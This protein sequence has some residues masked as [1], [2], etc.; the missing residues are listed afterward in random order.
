LSGCA[1][2]LARYGYGCCGLRVLFQLFR[3]EKEQCAESP[4]PKDEAAE[5]PWDAAS[6][7]VSG[8]KAA[9]AGIEKMHQHSREI[10]R[11]RFHSRF[12]KEKTRE[13]AKEIVEIHWRPLTLGSFA[14]YTRSPQK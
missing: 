1:E 14:Y 3:G 8:D 12:G 9:K 4:N 2:A 10:Q 13:I 6:A 11:I 7:A 5:R